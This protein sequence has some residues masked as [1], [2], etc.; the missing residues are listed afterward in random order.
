MFVAG[1]DAT[2]KAWVT[3]ERP[4]R[5]GSAGPASSISAT[6]RPR[7]PPRCTCRSGCGCWARPATAAQ[8]KLFAARHQN[9]R[10]P[11][12]HH[13]M[14]GSPTTADRAA[15]RSTSRRSRD[16]RR[17]PSRARAAAPRP[18]SG[19]A[20]RD[21]RREDADDAQRS[22]GGGARSAPP[23]GPAR[24]PD[25]GRARPVR[26]G[27]RQLTAS[28]AALADALAT[29]PVAGALDS[30]NALVGARLAA[31]YKMGSFSILDVLAGSASFTQAQS[32]GHLLPASGPAGPARRHRARPSEHP[33]LGIRSG[34]RRRARGG[35]KRAERV[36]A[37]QLAMSDK[38]AQRRAILEQLRA[39]S[40]GSSTASTRT[41]ASSRRCRCP[42]TTR[43]SPGRRRSSNSSTCRSPRRTRR[44]SRPGRWPRAATGTT[45]L[46]TTRSTRPCPSPGPPP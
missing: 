26:R 30:Q 10:Q 25:E 19:R 16:E 2:A 4:W 18:R 17:D 42:A 14:I 21:R 36:D 27:R 28:T 40:S 45:R 22:R 43:R 15:R 39:R 35:A 5:A 3:R 24:S 38:I 41:T 1:N 44:P 33:G 8:W 13:P 20:R 32:A 46:T 7:A 9:I 6:S 34:P 29:R 12:M 37:Q 31:M 11:P 23:D